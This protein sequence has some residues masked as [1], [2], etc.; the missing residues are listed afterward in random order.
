MKQKTTLFL[1]LL[2]FFK[3]AHS[4]NRGALIPDPLFRDIAQEFWPDESADK[5]V[6]DFPKAFRIEG[7]DLLLDLNELQNYIEGTESKETLPH[8]NLEPIADRIIAVI[9]RFFNGVEPHK[10]K[11][12]IHEWGKDSVTLG[13]DSQRLV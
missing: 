1:A 8:L 13:K 9:Q 7:E 3:D 11:K 10:L 5:I 2:D 6:R 12:Y 4:N